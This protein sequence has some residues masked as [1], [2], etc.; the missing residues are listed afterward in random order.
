MLKSNNAVQ[1]PDGNSDSG[2]NVEDDRKTQY[3]V[4]NRHVQKQLHPLA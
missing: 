2:G 4:K 1:Y 3:L